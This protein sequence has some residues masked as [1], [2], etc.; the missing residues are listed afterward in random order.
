MTDGIERPSE[1]LPSLTPAGRPVLIGI[2]AKLP[3]SLYDIFRKQSFQTGDFFSVDQSEDQSVQVTEQQTY[4]RTEEVSTW[5]GGEFTLHCT[6][7]CVDLMR[8]K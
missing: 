6:D 4:T 8:E 5:F 7:G 1:R 2:V 3:R